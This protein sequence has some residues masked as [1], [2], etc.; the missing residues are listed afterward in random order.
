M[1]STVPSPDCGPPGL[2]TAPNLVPT[3]DKPQRLTLPTIHTQNPAPA[4]LINGGRTMHIVAMD[5]P[6]DHF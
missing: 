3:Q 6:G 5:N 1:P 4:P 2:S